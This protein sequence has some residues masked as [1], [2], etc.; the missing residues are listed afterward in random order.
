MSNKIEISFNGEGLGF[1]DFDVD[2]IHRLKAYR[3]GTGF[4]LNIPFDVTLRKGRQQDVWPV[5]SDLRG[6]LLASNRK[7]EEVELGE[8]R[9]DER[10]KG[11]TYP[12]NPGQGQLTWRGT[13]ADLT[14]YERLRDGGH[15]RFRLVV[16]GLVSYYVAAVPNTNY[17]LRSDSHKVYGNVP[18][19][20]PVELW[21]EQLR[22]LGVA[23]NVLVEIP[24]TS[25]PPAPWD[26]VWQALV[27]ARTYFEQ[28]GSTGWK[29]CVAA[30]RLALEKWQSIEKEDMGPGWKAPSMQERQDRTKRQRLDN[31]RWHLYQCAHL[32]PHSSAEDWSRDDALLMLSTLT[33]LLA[34]RNP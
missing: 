15:V 33:V 14:Y 19:S 23:E 34:E 20:Y 22:A 5:L 11:P 2:P 27:E 25:S 6:T 1:I 18:L 8:L 32:G 31:V 24:L 7:G 13:F 9:D 12:N 28:G 10:Y 26:E 4:R 16:H 29:G 21:I 17:M 30:T 3:T